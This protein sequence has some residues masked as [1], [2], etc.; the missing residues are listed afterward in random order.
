[1]TGLAASG[2]LGY[3]LYR[4]SISP[5][6]RKSL[7]ATLRFTDNVLSNSGLNKEMRHALQTDRVLIVELMKLPTAPEGVDD[8]METEE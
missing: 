7:S 5:S 6:L 1:M 2:G 4:G 3:A 8:D